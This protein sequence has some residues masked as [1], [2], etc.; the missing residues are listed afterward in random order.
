MKK[1]VALILTMVLLCSL[2]SVCGAESKRVFTVSDVTEGLENVTKQGEYFTLKGT[3]NYFGIK[4]VDLTGIRSIELIGNRA[5]A[6]SNGEVLRVKTDSATGEKNIGAVAIG[7]YTTSG[8]MSYIGNIEPVSGVHDLYFCATYTAAGS[9]WK[10][11]EIRLS[12]EPK[13][14]RTVSDDAMI[15]TYSDTWT[16]VDDYGRKVADYEEVGDVKA[17][18]HILAMMYWQWHSDKN[19]SLTRTNVGIIPDII[20]RY[21]EARTNYYH[22]A[23][24]ADGKTVQ[25]SWYWGEPVFGFYTSHDYFTYRK[26]AQLFAL[27]GVDVLF[28]DNTNA[29]LC[30]P[31]TMLA[32][33]D[34]YLDAKEAG[35]RVPKLSAYCAMGQTNYA[36]NEYAAIYYNVL[37]DETYRDLWFTFDGKPM[38]RSYR[39]TGTEASRGINTKDADALRLRGALDEAFTNRA[40]AGRN[41]AQEPGEAPAWIWLE[42]YPQ[43]PRGAARADG[44]PEFMAVGVGINESYVDKGGATGVF[45]DPYAKGRG[46]SEGFGEDYSAENGRT[47]YFFRE[48]ASRALSVD[49]AVVYIDG[50]NE[51]TTVRY[52][53]YGTYKAAFVDLFDEENSRDFEPSR[54]YIKDDYFNL[55][56]D[57]SRKYKGVRPAPTASA[58]CTID[59]AGDTAAWESVAPSYLTDNASI[60]SE[61]DTQNNVIRSA[62]VARDSENFYFLVN[63]EKDVRDGK[64]FLTLYLNTDRC[65]AT[66]WNGYDYAIGRDGKG[67][68]S[69]Y[70]GTW[71]TVGEAAY[72]M[73]GNAFTLSVSRALIGETGTA[74]LEFKWTDG[75]TGDDYLDFYSVG[76]TAPTGKFNYLYTEIA[77]VSLPADTRAALSY[78]TVAKAGATKLY[79]NGGKVDVCEKDNRKTALSIGGTLY[80]PAEVCEDILGYGVAK[81]EYDWELNAFHLSRHDLADDGSAITNAVWSYTILD[82]LE[83]RVNGRPITL[84]HPV[85]AIDGTVYVPLTYMADVF[86]WQITASDDGVYVLSRGTASADAVAAAAAN[87]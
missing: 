74:D 63:T 47:A 58:P 52:A 49:P 77:Q 72:H 57:F 84:K 69:A 33:M 64:G 13:K 79:V 54:S 7:R 21:P 75:I 73:A 22:D 67:V 4:N 25:T 65:A 3:Q 55:L 44:R 45:S 71:K 12:E 18:D 40:H 34:A 9:E 16:C 76:C 87:L 78:T 83:A 1:A 23:W 35:V 53:T 66:G 38:I 43:M 68:V 81:Q 10:I 60:E 2:S 30:Y 56:V 24:L 39:P 31:E 51:W 32:M 5:A 48:Q 62:K 28:Y 70:D 36:Y 80:L 19:M 61:R 15:D 82:S 29:G 50:W 14:V 27:A 6:N 41:K 42:N 11:R 17:G 20:R 59:I 8:D 85:T 86:G 26:Q 37:A 46:Y